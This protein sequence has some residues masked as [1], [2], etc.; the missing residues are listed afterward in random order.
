MCYIASEVSRGC[1]P[2]VQNAAL[3]FFISRTLLR[4]LRWD[5]VLETEPQSPIN[6]GSNICQVHYT[7]F[8]RVL[9]SINQPTTLFKIVLF[10]IYQTRNPTTL[11]KR[12]L[13]SIFS[14]IT[15]LKGVLLKRVI[16]SVFQTTTLIKR[17]L[18]SIF[19]M[20]NNSRTATQPF[21]NSL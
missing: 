15:L 20:T 10:L 8:K 7:L 4:C 5:L 14:E 16:F 18:F 9:F 6:Y 21:F 1:V 19:L 2:A 17:V 13:F 3:I 12:V 11:F